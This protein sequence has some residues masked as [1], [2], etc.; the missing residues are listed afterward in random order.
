MKG[1]I[2]HAEAA[3]GA[4]GLAK[5][6]MMMKHKQIPHQA[7]LNNLNP[8]LNIP[9][10]FIIPRQL[11]EWILPPGSRRV[12]LLNNF[13]AAG[14]NVALLLEEFPVQQHDCHTPQR[15]C[16]TLNI[17]AK[18]ASALEH[19]K[20]DVISLIETRTDEVNITDLCYSA[21]ARREE[22]GQYRLSVT[23]ETLGELLT[24]LRQAQAVPGKAKSKTRKAVFVFSG[25][26][27]IHP[28][29]GAELLD[30]SPH[31]GPIVQACDGILSAHELPAVL[32][33][34]KGELDYYSEFSPQDQIIVSQCACFVLEYALARTWIAWGVVPDLVVG[35][36]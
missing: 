8:R 23:G 22:Y 19:L 34:L 7:S 30:T 20:T 36:R 12:A 11:S 1:T 29:M 24:G 33:Y 16:H 32:P 27:G 9:A 35:H 26:G 18:T 15:S 10:N 28:G 31:F 25:Q 6:L 21:N 13:G 2:G 17:T 4:A 14:S 5:L 3:S